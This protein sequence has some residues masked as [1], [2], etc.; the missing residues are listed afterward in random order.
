MHAMPISY[1][2]TNLAIESG[3]QHP[4]VCILFPHHAFSEG[5]KGRDSPRSRGIDVLIK[6]VADHARGLPMWE[7]FP[8]RTVSRKRGHIDFSNFQHPNPDPK[9]VVCMP[10]LDVLHV[11]CVH[12]SSS[13]LFVSAVACLDNHHRL[14]PVRPASSVSL[15]QFLLLCQ[16][17]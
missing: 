14:P 11:L 8:A 15:H 16:I 10:T 4:V 17:V 2:F 12:I 6:N 13:F 7:D 1:I 9:E 3:P 5:P